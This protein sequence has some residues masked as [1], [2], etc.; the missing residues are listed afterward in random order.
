MPYLLRKIVKSKRSFR[1]T[2]R[3][4]GRKEEWRREEK[5]EREGKRKNC[6]KFYFW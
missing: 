6:Y 1:R 3:E 4:C 2:S 5:K